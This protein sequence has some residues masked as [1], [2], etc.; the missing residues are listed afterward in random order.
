MLDRISLVIS[1]LLL[2]LFLFFVGIRLKAI[3][4]ADKRILVSDEHVCRIY[5]IVFALCA[6]AVFLVLAFRSLYYYDPTYDALVQGMTKLAFIQQHKSLFVHYKTIMV[7]TFSNEWLGEMN[8]LYYLLI[9]QKDQAIG[10]ANT[11]VWLFLFFLFLWVPTA[12]GYSGRYTGII[13]LSATATS[14]CF[15]LAVTMKTDLLSVGLLPFTVAL[16]YVYYKTEE[17]FYLFVSIVAIG[18]LAGS[19]I[20]VMPTAGLLAVALMIFIIF[21]A[22]KRSWFPILLGLFFGIPSNLRYILNLIQYGNPFQRVQNEKME[23]S[24]STFA[25][26]VKGILSG[27]NE[28]PKLIYTRS[29][30]SGGE[31]LYNALGYLGYTM[32]LVCAVGLITFLILTIKNKVRN[33]LLMTKTI[34]FIFIP[35]VLG[36]VFVLFSTPWYPWSF[37]YFAGY[38]LTVVLVFTTYLFIILQK[39]KKTWISIGFVLCMVIALAVPS[40]LNVA[41]NFRIGQ[42]IP[43]SLS[44]QKTLNSLQRKLLYVWRG[45]YDELA[46]VPGF[47]TLYENGGDALVLCEWNVMYYQYFGKD[48]CIH[49]DLAY[50]AADLL[51]RLNDRDYNIIVVASTNYSSQINGYAAVEDRL[52]TLGYTRYIT[53]NGALFLK[54]NALELNDLPIL[55]LDEIV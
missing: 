2:A 27:F 30:D 53:R 6:I 25:G 52:G 49:M 1:I 42:A 21:G 11:E 22:K 29:V 36:L 51:Q 45:N 55:S 33:T 39:V 23:I 32:L 40:V 35:F 44:T 28:T 37:R 17:S 4:T 16:L 14:V 43:V 13:S 38:V 20:T 47:L 31:V 48:H 18:A 5:S 50:D 24:F 34:V 3:V 7:N 15:G 12:F 54:S 9:S 46:A 19:K 41:A 8:G 26:N 10:F